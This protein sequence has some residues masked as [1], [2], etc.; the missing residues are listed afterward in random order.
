LD[1]AGI[2]VQ[3]LSLTA[4]ELDKLPPSTATSLARDVKDRVAQAPRRTDCNERTSCYHN[5]EITFEKLSLSFDS[6]HELKPAPT[7]A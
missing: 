3:V 6:G 4:S 5:G 7:A 1:E 2:T